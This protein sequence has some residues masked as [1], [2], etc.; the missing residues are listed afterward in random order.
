MTKIDDRAVPIDANTLDSILNRVKGVN[1]L[2]DLQEASLTYLDFPDSFPVRG[3]NGNLLGHLIWDEAETWQ[4]QP[5]THDAVD[6]DERERREKK[7]SDSFGPP[8]Y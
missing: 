7:T 3:M 1:K 8:A 2:W 4:F 5:A 6:L